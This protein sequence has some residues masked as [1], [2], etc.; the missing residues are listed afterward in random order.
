MFYVVYCNFLEGRPGR[1]DIDDRE[2]TVPRKIRDAEKEWI[3]YII[4]LGEREVGRD[5]FPVRDRRRGEIREMILSASGTA[6]WQR[7]QK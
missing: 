3:P 4:V 2:E 1:V 5:R 7:S 6:A